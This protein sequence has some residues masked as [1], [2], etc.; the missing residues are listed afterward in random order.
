MA[1]SM[2]ERIP[3][4]AVLKT[5]GFTDG[6]VLALLLAET[7]VFCLFCAGIGLGLAELAFPLVKKS[8][9]FEAAAGPILLAGLG[10]AVV[11]ALIAGLPPA[12]RAMR[13]QI[14]DALAGR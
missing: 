5:L 8:I 10:F 1:Q 3:E 4:L 2:R 6:G 7:L 14:V 12:L 11:L 9:G 13:L